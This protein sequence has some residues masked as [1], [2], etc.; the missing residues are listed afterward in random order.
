M[1]ATTGA[2]G[3]IVNVTMPA[4]YSKGDFFAP[5]SGQL[6]GLCLDDYASGEMGAVQMYGVVN[7]PK[8]AVN[9]TFAQGERV[10][11]TDNSGAVNKV[12]GTRKMCG[13][14][15]AASGNTATHVD[16]LLWRN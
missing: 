15:I 10:Y 1:V 11:C 4:A 13:Y 7:V 6:T 8:T 9:V 5:G 14:A 3:D 16:V 2:Q 12:G